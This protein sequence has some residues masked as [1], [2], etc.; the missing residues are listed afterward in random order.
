VRVAATPATAV[1]IAAVPS[2]G[3][4]GCDVLV[5]GK[6]QAAC[7]IAIRVKTHIAR[8]LLADIRHLLKRH[9]T[10]GYHNGSP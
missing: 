5:L 7:T 9:G 8:N 3:G 6:K 1:S 2:A 10:V 4:G